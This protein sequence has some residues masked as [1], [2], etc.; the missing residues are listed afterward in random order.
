MG[1]LGVGNDSRVVLYSTENQAWAARVWWMLRWIGFD[2]AA[3]LD[4][5]LNAWTAAGQPLSSEPV[6]RTARTLTPR[7]RPAL[8]ANR[9]EVLARGIISTLHAPCGNDPSPLRQMEL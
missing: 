5:G 2:N 8:I 6:M 1:A 3:L 4:G 9:D 7:V